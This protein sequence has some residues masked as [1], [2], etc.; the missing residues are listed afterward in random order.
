MREIG[1]MFRLP[2]FDLGKVGTL[3]K[4][5]KAAGWDLAE[6]NISSL[7]WVI[8][9]T[10]TTPKNPRPKLSGKIH[11]MVVEVYKNDRRLQEYLANYNA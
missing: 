9:K 3:V 10:P 1:K 8:W 7:E 5:L 11:G 4:S 2:G 6:Q